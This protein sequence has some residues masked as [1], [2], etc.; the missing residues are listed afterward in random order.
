MD[1]GAEYRGYTADI[2]RTIPVNGKFSKEQK[3]VYELVLKAQEEAM[4]ICK[5]GTTF[6]ELTADQR[7]KW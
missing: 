1:L 7:K 2:T 3:Q 4:K 5:E 6:V